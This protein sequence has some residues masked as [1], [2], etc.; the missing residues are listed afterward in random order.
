MRDPLLGVDWPT[1]VLREKLF[2]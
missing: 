1:L 2:V